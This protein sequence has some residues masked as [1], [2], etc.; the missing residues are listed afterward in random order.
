MNNTNSNIAHLYPTSFEQDFIGKDRYWK[1]IPNLPFLEIDMV[2]RTFNKYKIKISNDDLKRNV[3]IE[4]YHFN[5][6]KSKSK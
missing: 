6:K 1:G 3:E 4:N 2:N 5:E